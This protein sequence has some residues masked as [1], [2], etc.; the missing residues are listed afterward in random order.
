MNIIKL[1]FII[2]I[3]TQIFCSV[4]DSQLLIG[5][6]NNRAIKDIHLL[7]LEIS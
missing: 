4:Y 1:F 6:I 7:K 2:I 3:P 5:K